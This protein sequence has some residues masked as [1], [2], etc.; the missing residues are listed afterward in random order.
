MLSNF[1][2]FG[3]IRDGPRLTAGILAGEARHSRANLSL[4]PFFPAAAVGGFIEE[5]KE[6]EGRKGHIRRISTSSGGLFSSAERNWPKN[7]TLYDGCNLCFL[8][9]ISK[10]ITWRQINCLWMSST[11]AAGLFYCEYNNTEH[12]GYQHSFFAQT[13]SHMA[14]L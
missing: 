14:C 2:S 4:S 8:C 11:R 7:D 5:E 13:R 12:V 9:K 3:C 1:S 6:E 10:S